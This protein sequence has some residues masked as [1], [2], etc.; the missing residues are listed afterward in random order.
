MRNLDQFP[1]GMAALLLVSAFLSVPML[2]WGAMVAIII[3]IVGAA[4]VIAQL[5]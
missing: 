5:Q 4:Y 2:G 3:A 1:F